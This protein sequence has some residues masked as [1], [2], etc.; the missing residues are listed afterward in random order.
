MKLWCL[1]N[2]WSYDVCS[3]FVWLDGCPIMWCYDV[4]PTFSE[5][6]HNSDF[7][8]HKTLCF[9]TLTLSFGV[10][11]QLGQTL[12]RFEIDKHPGQTN[13]IIVLKSNKTISR[14]NVT[15]GRCSNAG[16]RIFMSSSHWFQAF[17]LL[18]PPK[19]KVLKVRPPK[20]RL[21]FNL[22]F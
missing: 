8:I 20:Q 22:L 16:I 11:N 2:K 4:C 10:K 19:S 3:T 18:R 15:V 7:P 17:L 12:V 1:S 14:K 5:G 13:V 9:S 21:R 6:R